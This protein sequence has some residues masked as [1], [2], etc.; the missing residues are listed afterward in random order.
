MIVYRICKRKHS[1]DLSGKGA[2]LVGGRWNSKG[3]AVLYTSPGIAL[4]TAEVAVHLP[5]GIMPDDFVLVMIEIPDT[6][7]YELQ[8]NELPLNWDSFPH[9]TST[10]Q[11]GNA[12][13]S[14]G[15]YLAIKVP[16]AA[17]QGEY[18]YI[19][20]PRHPEA[21]KMRVKKVRPYRFDKRLFDR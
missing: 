4:C 17:V 9:Q 16:S 8:E 10:Q 2:E 11:I 14:L 12:F 13:A 19:I 20:N 6:E 1:Q 21:A 7:V 5:L 15:R 3:V 18:N